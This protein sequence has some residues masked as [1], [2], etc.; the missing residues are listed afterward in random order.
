MASGSE[1]LETSSV[2]IWG[3]NHEIFVAVGDDPI[4][5][6]LALLWALRNFEGKGICILRVDCPADRTLSSRSLIIHLYI[7]RRHVYLN[8]YVY[9][10]SKFLR[11]FSS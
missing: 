9:E 10:T 4:K 11:E 3:E 8:V 5:N 1:D 6:K 7:Y 2:N